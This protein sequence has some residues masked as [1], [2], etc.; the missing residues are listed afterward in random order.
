MLDFFQGYPIQRVSRS[1]EPRA[2]K[3][4]IMGSGDVSR[5]KRVREGRREREKEEKKGWKKNGEETRRN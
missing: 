1:W 5:G 2:D 4:E 3:G